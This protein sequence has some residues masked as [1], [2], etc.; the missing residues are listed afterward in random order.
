MNHKVEPSRTGDPDILEIVSPNGP[1]IALHR[2]PSD[3]MGEFRARVEI[4]ARV[5]S[6][7]ADAKETLRRIGWGDCKPTDGDFMTKSDMAQEAQ[8]CLRTHPDVVL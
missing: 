3:S 4:L 2:L 5:C 6:F 8:R 1:F 7:A